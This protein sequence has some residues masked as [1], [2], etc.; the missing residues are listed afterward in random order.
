M[1]AVLPFS[2]LGGD[3]NDV[4]QVN[5]LLT[6]IA[7]YARMNEIY[8]EYFTAEEKPARVARAVDALPLGA[9]IEIEALAFLLQE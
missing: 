9:N 2:S 5:V 6:D 1:N 4:I 3:M 7:N 8:T